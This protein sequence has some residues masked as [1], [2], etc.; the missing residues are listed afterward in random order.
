MIGE[1]RKYAL[2]AIIGLAAISVGLVSAYAASLQQTSIIPLQSQEEVP[3]ETS[4]SKF[5][6][7]VTLSPAEGSTAE[8]TIRG[9]NIAAEGLM[10]NQEMVDDDTFKV[11]IEGT[12]SVAPEEGGETVTGA[13][14]TA[15]PSSGAAGS[16]VSIDGTG[17]QA[18]S[19]IVL[20]FDGA[21]LDTGFVT[22]DSDGSFF[23]T[24]TIPE[25]ATAGDHEL[26][27]S[28]IA[29]TSAVTPFTVEGI[30]GETGTPT[31]ASIT[32]TP[33][34]GA[35]GSAV[36][37]DGTGF[38]ANGFMT[39]TFDGTFLDAGSIVAGSDGSFSATVTIPEDAIAGD[40]EISASDGAGT[41]ASTAFTVEAGAEEEVTGQEA[42]TAAAITATPS[43]GA[44]GSQISIDG[45]G[46][47]ANGTI[48]I[49]FDGVAL[50]V[51][52]V[53]ADS[54]GSFFAAV[55]I[56]ADAAAGDHELSASDGIGTTATATFTVEAAEG[57]AA[58]EEG[59]VPPPEGVYP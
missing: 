31:S 15:N 7:S 54:N 22:A 59:L 14:I 1:F 51:G 33:S 40:H 24:V 43:S 45:T 38:E 29:G 25:D 56:P 42:P 17:F 23:A 48:T 8:V 34:S 47:E 46:F 5:M 35:A 49:T 12:F 13:S 53:I 18:D 2:A 4:D 58:P 3:E 50:D 32:V 11:I 27:A 26:S 44:A 55:A 28:D 37:V 36:T 52:S 6:S 10:V 9:T 30:E 20:A 57:G 41:I 39:L 16:Q 21:A 19:S